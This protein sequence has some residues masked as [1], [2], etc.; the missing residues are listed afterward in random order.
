LIGKTININGASYE[1]VAAPSSNMLYT[2]TNTG[3]Q[4]GVPYSAYISAV[5]VGVVGKKQ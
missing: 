4:T 3:T 2:L 5:P 1:V